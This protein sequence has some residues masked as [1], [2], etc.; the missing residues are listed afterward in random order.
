MSS[1][2]DDLLH[3]YL[4][5]GAEAMSRFCEKEFRQ[6]QYFG[7]HVTAKDNSYRVQPITQDAKNGSQQTE[8]TSIEIGHSVS[9]GLQDKHV[10]T[11]HAIFRRFKARSKMI[12]S[13]TCVSA[14]VL[15]SMQHLHPHVA[16]ISLQILLGMMWLLRRS[17]TPASAMNKSKSI[18]P[19]R[20]SNHNKLASQLWH[21][22]KR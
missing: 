7:I 8:N 16:S 5:Q 15:W 18:V 4:P 20:T 12:V 10:L 11:S 1:N 17:E 19:L 14:I 22:A 9:L 2:V 6:D 21:L 13:E 3:G